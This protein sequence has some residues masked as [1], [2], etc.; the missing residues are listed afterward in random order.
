MNIN[1]H[2]EL[3]GMCIPHFPLYINQV[4]TQSVLNRIIPYAYVLSELDIVR[5]MH[6]LYN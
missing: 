5:E 3:G 2:W 6:H 1:L 4:F